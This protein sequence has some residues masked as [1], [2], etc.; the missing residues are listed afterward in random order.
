M[1]CPKCGAGQPADNWICARRSIVFAKYRKYTPR[2]GGEA[3]APRPPTTVPPKTRTRSSSPAT[4][5]ESRLSLGARHRAR[6]PR[7]KFRPLGLAGCVVRP[8]WP[9]TVRAGSPDYARRWPRLRSRPARS[10]LPASH[11]VARGAPQTRLPGIFGAANLRAILRVGWL[12]MRRP[13]LV[14]AFLASTSASAQTHCLP[15]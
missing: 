12:N 6:W 2:P 11:P 15:G 4:P 9:D 14:A 7:S 8:S 3:P 10:P 5:G 13:F 1:Q